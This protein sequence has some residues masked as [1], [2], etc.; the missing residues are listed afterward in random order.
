MNTNFFI[1]YYGMG[2]IWWCY[3]PI[4]RL[5]WA[6]LSWTSVGILLPNWVYS[7]PLLF[8]LSFFSF[9]PFSFLLRSWKKYSIF[10]LIP[11]FKIIWKKKVII[12]LESSKEK[13]WLLDDRLENVK[14]TS[15]SNKI[16]IEK[17]ALKKNIQTKTNHIWS[18][19]EDTR[20]VVTQCLLN[21]VSSIFS[22]HHFN[23]F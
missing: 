14:V 11:S 15:N 21:F 19:S 18:L 10:F 3:G 6:L 20:T 7:S 16:E 9:S 23:N 13:I 12:I 17:K 22:I 8:F 5:G 4:I 1:Q 2:P